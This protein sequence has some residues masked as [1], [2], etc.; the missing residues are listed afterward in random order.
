M[1]RFDKQYDF[2]KKHPELPNCKVLLQLAQL[3]VRHPDAPTLGLIEGAA[4]GVEIEMT[5]ER[6]DG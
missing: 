2:A 1:A 4:K 5:S 3:Y 6:Q